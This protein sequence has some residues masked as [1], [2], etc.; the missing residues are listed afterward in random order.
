MSI[1]HDQAPMSALLNQARQRRAQPAKPSPEAPA[2][3]P[4]A[5]PDGTP[6]NA[7]RLVEVERGLAAL[8]DDTGSRLSAV[9]GELAV[10]ELEPPGP[11]T[12]Q[13]L[14]ERMLRNGA[15]EDMASRNAKAIFD[16]LEGYDGPGCVPL[17][18]RGQPSP[19]ATATERSEGAVPGQ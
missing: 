10:R 11:L 16:N 7:A 2:Q 8:T 1:E 15:T 13:Q 17:Q 4:P 18:R 14:Y 5:R 6:T 19:S 12:E 3:T 9:E